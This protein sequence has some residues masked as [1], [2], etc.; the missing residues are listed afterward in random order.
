MLSVGNE[1]ETKIKQKTITNLKSENFKTFS[2]CTNL[3]NGR[4]CWKGRHAP[5]GLSSR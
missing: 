1:T 3:L 4:Y 2:A 5:L